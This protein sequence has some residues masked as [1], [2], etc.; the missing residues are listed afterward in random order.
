MRRHPDSLRLIE[1]FP[2]QYGPALT[3]WKTPEGRIGSHG[4]PLA[5]LT[6]GAEMHITPLGEA[7]L[8]G[9]LNWLDVL[10]A[11]DR[12]FDVVERLEVQ[13]HLSPPASTPTTRAMSIG[14]RVIAAFLQRTAL[15]RDRWVLTNGAFLDDEGSGAH[16]EL[17]DSMP[18]AAKDRTRHQPKGHPLE[19]VAS[20][21][22]FLCPIQGG[23][24]GAPVRALD[25]TEGIIWIGD[26]RISMMSEFERLGRSLDRL[27][28]EVMPPAM[29]GPP[30]QP[31]CG[32]GR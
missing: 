15:E 22:W 23:E 14:P 10:L 6:L 18:E 13:L 25:T 32:R 20:R 28:N 5:L 9:R 1:V 19:L 27:V 31:P 26:R 8:E 3:V 11:P 17:F 4:H 30:R 2:H 16:G 21:Y 7:A 24:A 12:R 29:S